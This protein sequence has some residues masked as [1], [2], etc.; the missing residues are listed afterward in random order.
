VSA[1]RG[2]RIAG[3]DTRG[4]ILASAR[5]LFA[6]KGYTATTLRAVARDARV[7]PALIVHHFG[8]KEVLFRRSMQLP[9]DPAAIVGLIKT[10]DRDHVGERLVAYFLELWENDATR[11]PLLA[12]LRSA[13]THEGA[14][15]MLRGFLSEAVVGPVSA[16]LG[17]PDPALRAT[18]TGS[19]LVGLAMARYVVRI[20]P[21]A[22]AD[23]ATVTAWVAPSI[24]RYLTA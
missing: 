5:A 3:G 20:E 9:L 13:F 10:G 14:A 19:H 16:A 21:L 12:I 1:R 2:R 24:Q 7:D 11:D 6:R 4:E 18:L 8:S 17:V 22:S 15:T 23:A